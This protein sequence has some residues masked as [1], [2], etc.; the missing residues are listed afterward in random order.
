MCD[1]CVSP[2]HFELDP[3]AWP[4]GPGLQV[5]IPDGAVAGSQIKFRTAAGRWIQAGC[6]ISLF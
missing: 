4:D 2:L 6:S 5:Q 3:A 1:R